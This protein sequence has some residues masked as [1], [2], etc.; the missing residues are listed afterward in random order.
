MDRA[1][2]AR[3]YQMPHAFPAGV[4]RV[5]GIAITA[6]RVDESFGVLAVDTIPDYHL[7][8]AGTDTQFLPRYVFASA[9]RSLGQGE[10]L[11][12]GLE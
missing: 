9:G 1:L 7:T 3:T 12:D 10:L 6:K 8:G 4:E 5:P 2:N 11:P